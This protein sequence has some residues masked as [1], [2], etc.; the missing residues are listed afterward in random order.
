MQR[1]ESI[2]ETPNSSGFPSVKTVNY[3]SPAKEKHWKLHEYG[4]NATDRSNKITIEEDKK[5]TK[6]IPATCITCS[7]C[8]RHFTT[9]KNCRR[10]RRLVHNILVRPKRTKLPCANFVVEHEEPS[11]RNSKS[12]L[13]FHEM[14]KETL[15]NDP[16]AKPNISIRMFDPTKLQGSEIQQRKR[17]KYQKRLKW[18]ISSNRTGPPP[19]TTKDPVNASAYANSQKRC[20]PQRSTL[21]RRWTILVN[22]IRLFPKSMTERQT[23]ISLLKEYQT[24][25]TSASG[26][27]F[28][29]SS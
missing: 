17:S 7:I 5:A 14:S 29:N 28:Y 3:R 12:S 16:T 10:H 11:N 25:S 18:K 8:G 20:L 27:C 24:K 4:N 26:E 19:S 9:K 15:F 13:K 21:V 23:I 1:Q 2:I 6:T 22:Q